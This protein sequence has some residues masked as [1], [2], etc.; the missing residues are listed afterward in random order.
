MMT[1]MV[2][3]EL[4][5]QLDLPCS[6][7]TL[8]ILPQVP[9][10]GLG[11][12]S[13]FPSISESPGALLLRLVSLRPLPP[14]VLVALGPTHV[15]T[16]VKFSALVTTRLTKS[17]WTKGRSFATSLK[18]WGWAGHILCKAFVHLADLSLLSL[19]LSPLWGNR[20]NFPLPSCSSGLLPLRP[21]RSSA[22]PL[23]SRLSRFLL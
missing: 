14:S 11:G 21:L 3:V 16:G 6:F 7:E 12:P 17:A 4:C 19:L 20:Q 15:N 18:T 8:L 10:P 13:H 2:M 23:V 5:C 22:L 9:I 1:V